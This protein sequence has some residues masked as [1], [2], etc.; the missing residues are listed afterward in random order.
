MDTISV[1]APEF[2]RAQHNLATVIER[3]VNETVYELDFGWRTS[4][5]APTTFEGLKQE[6]RVARAT[7][8]E[9]RVS[10]KNCKHTIYP[11]AI[12]NYRFRFWH[13]TR[14]VLLDADFSLE[15]EAKVAA[16][17]LGRLEQAGF[18]PQSLE[19]QMFEADGL[20]QSVVATLTG[21][22]PVNQA[23]FVLNCVNY[24]Q[25]EA[26]DMEIL[27]QVWEEPA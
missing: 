7:D 6:F 3:I 16:A 18:G 9:F 24:G 1:D 12:T 15:G 5:L 23:R 27:N 11:N 4:P 26:V 20:G 25:A 17:Q 10:D 19:H 13:D 8:L 21:K 14:H 2:Q 22:F